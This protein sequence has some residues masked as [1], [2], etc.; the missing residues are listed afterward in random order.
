V[1]RFHPPFI[2][3]NL[4]SAADC[5]YYPRCQQ[6]CQPDLRPQLHRFT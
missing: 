6:S 3:F 2:G 5:S 1:R 4:P